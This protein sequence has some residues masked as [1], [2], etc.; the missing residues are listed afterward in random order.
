MRVA[1]FGTPEFAVPEA[2]RSLD[3]AGL[4]ALGP[5]AYRERLRGSPLKRARLEGLRRNASLALAARAA[6][7]RR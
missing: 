4:L 3:L 2:R 1:F 7:G 6:E 5:E